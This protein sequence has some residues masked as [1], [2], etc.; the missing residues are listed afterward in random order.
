MK[1][2]VQNVKVSLKSREILKDVT[3]KL[4]NGEI[5]A[6]LGPNGS[7]KSTLLRTIFG[8]LKP[9]EGVVL[10]DGKSMDL[11][12][13]AKIAAYLPQEVPETKLRVIDVVLLGRTPHLSGIKKATRKDLYIALKALKAV[14]LE[15]FAERV[16][17]ELSGGEKQKVMLARLFAQEPKIMLLDEPTAHLDLSAQIEIM[18]L[19]KS[20]VVEGSSAIVALHDI[21]LAA[22]F[23]D[24]IVML[25]NG[26]IHYEGRADEV[27][28]PESIREIYGI[29]SIVKKIGKY[30][31]VT[32]KVISSKN[33]KHVHVICGGGSGTAIIQSLVEAGYRVSAGVLNVLDSDWETAVDLGCEVICEAPFSEI[34][35]EN[36][37]KNL[38][39]VEEANAVVLTNLNLG[40]G[41][42]KN[43]FAAKRASEL[44]KLV[45]IE[46]DPFKYRNF[47]GKVA[48]EVYESITKSSVIVKNEGD[49]IEAVR[50]LVNG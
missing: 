23:A 29:D 12:E 47:A 15:N 30:V 50:I 40:K 16:F 7:G 9:M 1:L 37:N 49:A 48:E 27:L 18:R 19:V 4:E 25:K 3:L 10:Y 39:L 35:E 20:K 2:E 22:T 41:N 26:V 44:K 21:N 14:N 8:I 13:I 32:P 45:V 42:L 24:K 38:K 46:K 17:N 6:V 31:F 28:T 11:D 34:S 33:G 36:H 43:L 5:L